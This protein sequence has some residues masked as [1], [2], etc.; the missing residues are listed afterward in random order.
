[1][2]QIIRLVAH[3]ERIKMTPE[4]I[5]RERVEFEEFYHKEV[6]Y[7]VKSGEYINDYTHTL[8]EG[9]LARAE[10]DAEFEQVSWRWRPVGS[11]SWIYDPDPVWIY[12]TEDHIEKEIIYAKKD[13]P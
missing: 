11:K 4:Q 5:E 3:V 2:S 10:R 1:M 13:K 8:W 6:L 7:V 12:Q 9:W